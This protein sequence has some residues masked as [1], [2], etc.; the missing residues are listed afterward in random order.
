MHYVRP[1]GS[2]LVRF[3]LTADLRLR[4]FDTEYPALNLRNGLVVIGELRLPVPM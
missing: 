1:L 2:K 3:F 4:S